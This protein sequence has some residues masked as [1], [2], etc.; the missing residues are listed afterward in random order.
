MP[1]L[2]LIIFKK[3]RNAYVGLQNLIIF[4]FFFEFAGYFVLRKKWFH[5]GVA[6]SDTDRAWESKW[7]QLNEKV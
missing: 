1:K 6:G 5:R 7:R 2:Y 4:F 3:C